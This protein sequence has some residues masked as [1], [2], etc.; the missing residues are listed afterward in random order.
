MP[1][2]SSPRG[3]LLLPPAQTG[4]P[5]IGLQARV[6]PRLNF[7][8]AY[9]FTYLVSWSIEYAHKITAVSPARQSEG[10]GQPCIFTG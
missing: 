5:W 10:I 2:S 9:D 4:E 1:V 7:Q 3:C 8:Q 6:H